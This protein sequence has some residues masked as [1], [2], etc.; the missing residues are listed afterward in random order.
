MKALPSGYNLDL[1]EL[2]PK[3]WETIDIISSSMIMLSE[4]VK[5]LNL[6]KN[7]FTKK[8]LKYSTTTE[9]ANLLVIKYRIPF[10]TSHK[11]IGAVVKI[12][13]ENNLKLSDLKPEL[14]NKTAKEYAGIN[15]A[16]EL[17]DIK[18]RI[19]PKKFVESHKAMGG[20]APTEVERMLKNRLELIKKSE[21]NLNEKN[22]ILKKAEL[23]MK[24]EIK[25]YIHF[26]KNNLNNL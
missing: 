7:V 10:R 25:H 9:L 4:L 24:S 15:L 13:L 20:P 16:V 6:N 22:L 8:V 21:D 18:D 1:Q 14:I 11:I 2:T 19:N 12:L 5:N 26:Q 23:L 3:L 17:E